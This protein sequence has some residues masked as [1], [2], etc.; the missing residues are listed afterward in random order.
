MRAAPDRGA[1]T[2]RRQA[3]ARRRSGRSVS[4]RT[5]RSCPTPDRLFRGYRLLQE[6]FAFPEKFLFV[7]LVGLERL[8]GSGVTDTLEVRI[9]LGRPFA[10]ERSV[11]GAD[12]PPAR[13][14]LVNVFSQLAE[15]IR[16]TQL[17]H[18]YRVIPNLGRRARTR[19]GPSTA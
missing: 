17:K 16:V 14:P 4:A 11:I 2:P 8:E 6:Y 9:L 15:P 19:S 18:E 3:A 13:T 5:R 7:D 12:L 10:A 1:P